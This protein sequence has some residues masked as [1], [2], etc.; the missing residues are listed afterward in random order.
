MASRLTVTSILVIGALSLCHTIQAEPAR[1]DMMLWYNEPASEWVE[2][3][4]VGNGR[5]GAMVFGGVTQARYQ[6]NEDSLW[7]GAPHDYARAGAHEVLPELRKLLFQ[8]Q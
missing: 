3:L 2:A 8:R 7:A 4:P 1:S 5:L 6:L